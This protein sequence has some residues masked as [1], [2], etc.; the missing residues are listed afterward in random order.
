[1]KRPQKSRY[2]HFCA[3]WRK[4][5]KF[6]QKFLL[7]SIRILESVTFNLEIVIGDLENPLILISVQFEQKTSN[8]VKKWP[9]SWI[10]HFEFLIFDLGIVHGENLMA[11]FT[12]LS[13]VIWTLKFQQ[14]TS[15]LVKNG[16]HIQYAI[17]N[18]WILTAAS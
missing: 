17:L 6:S 5:V 3:I 2:I 7:Y 9:P 14:K 1:M 10:R 15:N 8:L 16:R 12:T 18:F 4:K 11:I 13:V